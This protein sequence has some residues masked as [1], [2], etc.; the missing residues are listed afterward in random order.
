M[1]RAALQGTAGGR[2]T[3]KAMSWA[4]II[5][6]KSIQNGRPALCPIPDAA[7]LCALLIMS[8]ID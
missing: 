1:A 3:S 7:C 5:E 6:F 2:A 8:V 4:A